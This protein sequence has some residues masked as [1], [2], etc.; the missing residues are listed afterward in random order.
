MACFTLDQLPAT[1]FLSTSRLSCLSTESPPNAHAAAP[2]R[3]RAPPWKRSACG[4]GLGAPEVA[5]TAWKC[6]SAGQLKE[7]D[8][9]RRGRKSRFKQGAKDEENRPPLAGRPKTEGKSRAA[10]NCHAAVLK[11][12]E[13]HGEG[14][15]LQSAQLVRCAIQ[16]APSMNCADVRPDAHV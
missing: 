5:R 15:Q 2:R 16:I 4:A 7:Q 12:L 6:R 3:L 1:C 10:A 11:L 8:L 9:P 13:R 14:G